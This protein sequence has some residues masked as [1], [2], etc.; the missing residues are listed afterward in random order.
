MARIT[1]AD[2]ET[3]NQIQQ[4]SVDES[5]AI[6]GGFIRNDAVR[7]RVEDLLRSVI[8]TDRYKGSSSIIRGILGLDN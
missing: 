5:K 2:I 1:I 7:G 4:L 3:A 8:S 6:Q